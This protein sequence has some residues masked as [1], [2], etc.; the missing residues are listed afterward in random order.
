MDDYTLYILVVCEAAQPD[1]DDAQQ[2]MMK[3]SP[4]E[5]ILQVS[6]YEE[7]EDSNADLG[8]II[9]IFFIILI[10]LLPIFVLLISCCRRR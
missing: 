5:G 10:F 2:Q 3:L 6:F 7:E 1:L 4:S 9:G 8:L